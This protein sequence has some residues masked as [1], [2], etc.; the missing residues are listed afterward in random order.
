M[1]LDVLPISF[2][3]FVFDISFFDFNCDVRLLPWNIYI[4]TSYYATFRN[5]KFKYSGH[6][7]G[8]IVKK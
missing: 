4:N 8:V 5:N 3:S 2:Q 7:L 1:S 6:F